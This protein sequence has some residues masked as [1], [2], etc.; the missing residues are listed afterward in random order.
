MADA[1]GKGGGWL[2]MLRVIDD[3]MVALICGDSRKV[4]P[5][6]VLPGEKVTVITDPVWPNNRVAEFAE[7]DPF[8]LFREVYAEIEKIGPVRLA[9]QI[10]CDSDPKLLAPVNMP[11]FRYVWMKFAVPGYK[12]R[13]LHTGDVAFL[14][15]V[16]PDAK[17]GKRCIPGECVSVFPKGR[18]ND[19]PCPRKYEHVKWLIANWTEPDDIVLDPFVGSGQTLRA[20]KEL[21]RRSIGIEI[22]P[23]FCEIAVQNLRQEVMQFG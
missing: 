7:I 18:E 19:H 10:G 15:G 13:V 14:Y 1:Y 23:E 11:F 17:Y 9:V 6:L 22:A 12:G 8:H 21:G 2:M 20:A 3:S 4:I 5:E 16:P